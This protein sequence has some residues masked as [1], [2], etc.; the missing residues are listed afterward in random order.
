MKYFDWSEEKNLKLQAVR[1]ISFEEI[2]LAI[3]QGGV[4]DDIAHPDQ[5]KYPNQKILVV[6]YDG[7]AY[8]VPYIEEKER[9]FLKTIYPSRKA[10]R[11]YLKNI[12]E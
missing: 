11:K 4:L 3:T 12:E 8:L 7:Y 1:G 5:K 2:V 9:Y 6:E 10:S